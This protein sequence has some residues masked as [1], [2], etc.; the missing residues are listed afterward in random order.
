MDI[1]VDDDLKPLL[2][3]IE[4][5]DVI[6]LGSHGNLSGQIRSF[7]DRLLFQYLDYGGTVYRP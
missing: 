4:K 2:P 3:R 1:V 5:S 6:V 7:T